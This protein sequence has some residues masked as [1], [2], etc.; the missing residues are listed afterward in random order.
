MGCCAGHTHHTS[1]KAQMGRKRPTSW[2]QEWSLPFLT[3]AVPQQEPPPWIYPGPGALPR[4]GAGEASFPE[5]QSPAVGRDSCPPLSE[6][7]Q[8]PSRPLMGCSSDSTEVGVH[9]E[10]GRGLGCEA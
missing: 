4:E 1:T 10:L 2:P 7:E 8:D 3:R 9:R 5:M 6:G